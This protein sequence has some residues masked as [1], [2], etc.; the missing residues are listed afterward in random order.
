MLN[1]ENGVPKATESYHTYSIPGKTATMVPEF[2]VEDLPF[3]RTA[4]QVPALAVKELLLSR[5][6]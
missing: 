6:L 5:T 1:R 4:A 3:G 2:P